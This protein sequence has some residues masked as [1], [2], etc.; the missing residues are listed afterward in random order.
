MTTFAAF[1]DSLT[2]TP[3]FT[4]VNGAVNAD[5]THV[6]GFSHGEYRSYQVAE[7]TVPVVADV[8]VVMVG[9]NDVSNDMWRVPL[10]VTLSAIRDIV[11]KS[12]AERA[13]IAA[14]PPRSDDFPVEAAR[15]NA[16]IRAYVTDMGWFWVDPWTQFRTAGGRWRFGCSFDGIHP[17]RAVGK[18]AG[19]WMRHFILAAV[20]VTEPDPCPTG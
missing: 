19:K 16:D 13:V 1:G 15:L 6:G 4:W 7:N 5:V 11:V 17:T 9:T 3:D 8:T 18:V 10:E 12:G 20:D 14:M 2:A